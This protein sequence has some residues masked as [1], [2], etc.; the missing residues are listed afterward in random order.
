MK[1]SLRKPTAAIIAI[2]FGW[3]LCAQGV[4][5]LESSTT[6]IGGSDTINIARPDGTRGGDLLLA[7]IALSGGQNIALT[8]PD[9]WI[10]L[11]RS[12]S[13]IYIGMATY[14]RVAGSTEPG[15]YQFIL[16]SATEWSAG[17]SRISQANTNSPIITSS[18]NAG[19]SG[20]A[21]ALS[22]DTDQPEALVLAF[23]SN[24]ADA[25]FTPDPSTDKQYDMPNVPMQRPSGMLSTFTQAAAGSTGDK[26]AAPSTSS[27]WI[28][29]QIAVAPHLEEPADQSG[30]TLG[31]SVTTT[32][33][34]QAI[35]LQMTGVT[36]TDGTLL[37]GTYT[38]W[39]ESNTESRSFVFDINFTN[40]TGS[41]PL[42]LLTVGTH[43]LTI[44]ID[45]ITS[46]ETLAVTIAP[47][48]VTLAATP[49]SKELNEPD[50]VLT[51]TLTD[52]TLIANVPLTGEL[53]R[54][55]GEDA[56][57]YAIQQGSLTDANNPNYAITFVSADLEIIAP[58]PL[59]ATQTEP[60]VEALETTTGNSPA[61]TIA[62][63][64][65]TIA[66]DLLV[67]SLILDGGGNIAISAPPGW[68]LIRRR[69]NDTHIGIA[70]YYRVAGN[71]EPPSYSFAQSQTSP[72]A[73]GIARVS[74]IDPI[75]PLI[76]SS[77]SAGRRGS[78]TA[79]SVD[80][81]RGNTLVM[82]YFSN[83]SDATYTPPSATEEQYDTPNTT[84]GTPSHMLATMKKADSGAS[85][86]LTA[87][88]KFSRRWAAQQVVIAGAAG[89]LPP[90]P[91]PE[92]LSSCNIQCTGTPVAGDIA[93]LYITDAKDTTGTLLNGPA[94]SIV[95]SSLDNIVFN[96]EANFLDGT[97]SLPVR[98]VT[99][100]PH[101][102]T[103]AIS[104][105][106]DP[107]SLA[108]T[109]N[110]RPVTITADSQSKQSGENDPPLTH[111]ISSGSLMEES[112]L[113]GQLSREPGEDPG[114]YTIL[115]GSLIN[116]NNPS[117]S[118]TFNPG[119]LE[120]IATEP[121]PV[122]QGIWIAPEE[123][124]ALPMSGDPWTE[125]KADADTYWGIPNISDQEDKANIYTMSKAL[126][127]ART[128]IESYRTD[129]I[130]ACTQAIGTE[131][132][133][134]ALA[135]G[136][137]LAA[138]IIA[139]DLVG[140]PPENDAL[141]REWLQTLPTKIMADGQ[142]LTSA[143]ETKPTNWGTHPGASRAAIAAYLGDQAE[144]D[145]CAQIFKGWLGDRSSYAGF[146]FTDLS[147]QS[148]PN[149]PVAINPAGATIQGYSVD[150]ALPEEQ[151]RNG[152]F[153]W[154]P[155]KV[156]TVYEALQGALVQAVILSRAGY[157]VWNWE[158][159]ALR[160]VFT[161]LHD[162]ADYPAEWDDLWQPFI[163]NSYYNTSFP[164]P[165]VS[166]PGK[167]IARTCWT[168]SA[169][170]SA[171]PPPPPPTPDPGT[172]PGSED[173]AFYSGDYSNDALIGNSLPETWRPFS[174]DSPWNTPIP[175][176]AT[177]H[178]ESAQIISFAKT[179]ASNIRLGAM[180]QPPVW[181]VN[182]DN[183]LPVNTPVNSSNPMELH[184]EH[185]RSDV[186][187][188]QWDADRD[189]WS[190]VP[191]PLAKG[192]Y[193]EPT[194]D[195]HIIMI[196]PFRK[197][198]YEMSRY[199][200]WD[201]D[202]P[203]CTTFNIWDLSG[204]GVGNPYEGD[205]WWARGGRGSGFPVI[206]GLLRPEELKA[207]E[208][209]HALTFTFNM[210]RRSDNDRPIMM[211]PPACRS[212]GKHMGSQYPIEGM[213]FQ[214]DPTLTEVDFDRWGLTKEVKIVARALQKYGMYL[215][216]NG[217]AMALSVQLLGPDSNANRAEWDSRF[218]NFY[219]SITK[220]PTDKFRVVYTVEP[221]I[222]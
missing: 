139:A 104:D 179:Q 91:T 136:R 177:T 45:G 73:A 133:G 167:N 149:N 219:S 200:G 89:E 210:N 110:R 109:V 54:E 197:T 65:G 121:P 113:S 117:Y 221:T 187:F 184:W 114:V 80:V 135:L 25:T 107:Q 2:S 204:T 175:A 154:P 116:E 151:Q 17:I 98:L 85:G 28:A 181:V 160:R 48:P 81:P 140:L 59:P 206:A 101:A 125:L 165:I 57:V 72:W 66:G 105:I 142:S 49:L 171:P 21:I 12:N 137:N 76:G 157:D 220:I 209:R 123:L 150:G 31:S 60:V 7:S 131:E 100:G 176:D 134:L 9:G 86:E 143:H 163:I 203:T 20:D 152:A 6:A 155:P 5:Q 169:G 130:E 79:A 208:I 82:A 14:Y 19:S 158:D 183:A 186:I 192:A 215:G 87:A 127:Y 172:D 77:F 70:T 90:P 126:V 26:T 156:G 63:P 24:L 144:L 212:D 216:D 58:P 43:T 18:Q 93:T 99:T 111:S 189:G 218:P 71:S 145:R 174:A 146:T 23:F 214:L 84:A 222:R 120:I 124:S 36:A 8:A 97:A 168:H 3:L 115:Q 205:R 164:T 88:P 106:T 147:W 118:I 191:I 170:Y 141:F 96:S 161:W 35:T 68:T 51:Y 33:S 61:I 47:Q 119:T 178:P 1:A 95:L 37:N 180:Y 27:Q 10:L 11:R 194:E 69:N 112:P 40:G 50:P 162:S 196:D 46:P 62:K 34:G 92:D 211:Y 199:N 53:S 188:D 55:S 4:P 217:G 166:I 38:V 122:A 159:Q 29:Q 128:G 39:I 83:L 67:A 207:G 75:T 148:D 198:S 129:V 201:T 190:D 78:V 52:G 103:V 16:N 32:E 44:T 193:S 94:S 102:L 22:I 64:V 74:G 15:S 132:G 56:G 41:T 202:P 42:S 213:L 195:G 13:D 153:T 173:L 185:I 108:I 138:F 30:F 182:A